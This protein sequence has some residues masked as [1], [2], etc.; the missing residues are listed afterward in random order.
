MRA[1]AEVWFGGPVGQHDSA[2]VFCC[3]LS[4]GPEIIPAALGFVLWG[5]TCAKKVTD[6]FCIGLALKKNIEKICRLSHH[7]RIPATPEES[8][9]VLVETGS[10]NE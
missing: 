2:W 8:P 6:L 1:L 4:F 5:H 9:T 7:G 10:V 3:D